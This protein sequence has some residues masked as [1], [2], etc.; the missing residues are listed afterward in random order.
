M[1]QYI[2]LPSGTVHWRDYGGSGHTI[3]LVHGLGGSI[4]N[5]N[6]ITEDLA[7]YGRVVALDLPGFGLS[8]PVRDWSLQTQRDVIVEFIHRF[9]PPVTLIGNSMGGLLSEMVASRDPGL[10]S[11]LV[12][13]APATPP[14]LP[15][16]RIDWPTAR[17][18]LFASLPIVGPAMSRHIVA[19]M[20][21]R[22]LVEDSVRRITYKPGRVPLQL[23]E[24]LVAMAEK[25]RSFPWV[26]D[27]VPMTGREIRKTFQKHAEFVSMIRDIKTPT[28]VIQGTGDH[29][30]SPTSVQWLCGLR[31]DW[32]L[33]QMD[34]TGHT[35]QIDAPVRF[36]GV[37]GSWLESLREREKSA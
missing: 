9:E 1:S 24:D 20:T 12:L 14:R 35:P 13:V 28:L 19:S 11:A 16:P 2:D 6:L 18:L 21:P 5:W 26:A 15:D 29:I 10:L 37:L 3:V 7:R 33:V 31:P 25:R 4:E 22:E 36:M 34:E 27:A 30:V 32:A 17:Q 23:I 8:P